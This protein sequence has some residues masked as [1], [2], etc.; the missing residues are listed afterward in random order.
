MKTNSKE[1]IVHRPMIFHGK[2]GI[3]AGVESHHRKVNI[4]YLIGTT[5]SLDPVAG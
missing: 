5:L 4:D 2:Y 3:H 1:E